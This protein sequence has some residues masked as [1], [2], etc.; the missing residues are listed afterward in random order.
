VLRAA[1]TGAAGQLGRELVR[2]FTDAGDEVLPLSRPQF[3]L[4]DPSSLLNLEAWR[5][6]VVVNSAAYTDVDG[7]ARDPRLAMLV[8]GDGAAAVARAAAAVDAL[9]VQ[10]STNEVFDGTLDRPYTEDDEPNPINPY[11]ISKLAGER[12]VAK[13]NP[14]HLIVRTAWLFGPGGENFVTKIRAAARRATDANQSLRVVDDEW[15]N[16]TPTPWLAE[17][18]VWLVHRPWSGSP[19]VVHVAGVPAV[20]RHA[21]AV[22]CLRDLHVSV[23]AIPSSEY[24]RASRPPLCAVLDMTRLAEL[25][26]PASGWHEM[27][28]SLAHAEP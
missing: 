5:P 13:A 21:W 16:P 12:G 23:D 19:G 14:R 11:G 17:T 2:A 7:C 28:E 26:R 9:V 20:T 10:I 24:Q 8:N 27:T 6:D 3:D 18:I 22:D 15:G 4:R 25:G 1:I